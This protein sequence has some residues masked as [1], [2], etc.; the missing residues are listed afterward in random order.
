MRSHAL[1]EE[2]KDIEAAAEFWD[3]HSLADYWDQTE[4]IH[5]DVSHQRSVF[6]VPLQH[7]L[8]GRLADVARRQGVSAETLVNLWVS[9]H[10]QQ[11][12]G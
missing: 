2:F 1:P 7:N 10:L 3:T 12:A 4:E 11:A 5:F 6:L 8:A 9:D